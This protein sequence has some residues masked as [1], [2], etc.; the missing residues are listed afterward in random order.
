LKLCQRLCRHGFICLTWFVII[1]LQFFRYLQ[2]REWSTSWF[3]S[4]AELLTL[5]EQLPDL[6]VHAKASNTKKKYEYA[7]NNFSKWCISHNISFLPA[8]DF[9]VT[10]FL[11]HLKNSGKA[12]GSIDEMFYAISWAHKLAGLSDPCISDLTKSEKVVSGVL[13]RKCVTKNYRS[14]QTF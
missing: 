8:S 1:L 5:A 9:H 3:T 2:K 10:L 7:F 4:D 12:A 6:C 13:E 14:L 11:T